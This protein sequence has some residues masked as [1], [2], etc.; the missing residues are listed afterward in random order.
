MEMTKTYCIP[1]Q[2]ELGALRM[3]LS[4]HFGTAADVMDHRPVVETA[5]DTLIQFGSSQQIAQA[6]FDLGMVLTDKAEY[7]ATYLY[8]QLH[9]K[10]FH[11]IGPFQED[12]CYDYAVSSCGDLYLYDQGPRPDQTDPWESKR[13]EVQCALDNGDYIPERMRRALEL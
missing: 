2:E 1:V 4:E 11:T 3:L 5:V 7:I 8:N 13:R 9:H 10:L 12:H 6:L